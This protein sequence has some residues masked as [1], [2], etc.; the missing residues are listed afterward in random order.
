MHKH[1]EHYKLY[2]AL[3]KKLFIVKNVISITID[4]PQV[5]LTLSRTPRKAEALCTRLSF[6]Q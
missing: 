1:K 5:G 2:Y 4:Y 3:M 6:F